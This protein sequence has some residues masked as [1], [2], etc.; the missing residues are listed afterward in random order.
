MPCPVQRWMEHWLEVEK[1]ISPFILASTVLSGESFLMPSRPLFSP[2][3][4]T[5][6]YFSLL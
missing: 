1:S 3:S 6:L 4:P 5:S 2:S